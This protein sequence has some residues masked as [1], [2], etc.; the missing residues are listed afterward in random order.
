MIR[1][2]QVYKEEE[3]EWVEGGEGVA[4]IPRERE[5]GLKNRT[6]R[7]DSLHSSQTQGCREAQ[8]HFEIVNF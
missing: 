8:P 7:P 5:M 3:D 1:E 2:I 4:L 6:Q